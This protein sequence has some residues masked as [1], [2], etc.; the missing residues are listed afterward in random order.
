MLDICESAIIRDECTRDRGGG[1][2]ARCESGQVVAS[3]VIEEEIQIGPN[4][5]TKPLKMPQRK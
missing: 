5:Q 1:L 4:L 3:T 2:H